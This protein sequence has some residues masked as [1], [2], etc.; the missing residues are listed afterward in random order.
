MEVGRNG[1]RREERRGKGGKNGGRQQ[2]GGKGDCVK[3]VCC[4]LYIC[5]L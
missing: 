2:G 3:Y 4:K 5:A 1:G